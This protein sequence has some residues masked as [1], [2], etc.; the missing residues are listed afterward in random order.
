MWSDQLD[1]NFR[2]DL[3][4][5]TYLLSDVQLSNFNSFRAVSPMGWHERDGTYIE[6]GWEE[7]CVLWMGFAAP[8]PCEEV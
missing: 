5:F 3:G 7:P 2:L 1:S 8:G 4:A 6:W